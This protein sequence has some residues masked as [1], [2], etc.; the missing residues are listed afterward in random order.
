MQ[1]RRK[2]GSLGFN[3]R[4]EFNDSDLDISK[5]TLKMFINSAIDD[6]NIPFDA[7]LYMT[8]H[9][10]Y[11]GRVTDDWDRVCLLSILKS[12]YGPEA[13]Q[14]GYNYSESGIYYAP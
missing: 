11:G 9:I 2:F 8:G 3:I 14:K 4:Y 13:L 6:E 1:E 10:N 7:M 5:T 12:F